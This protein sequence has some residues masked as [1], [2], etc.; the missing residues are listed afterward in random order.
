MRDRVL[1]SHE[2]VVGVLGEFGVVAPEESVA[3]GSGLSLTRGSA[4]CRSS[5][6]EFAR[7][8]VV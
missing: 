3:G 2:G 6:E 1:D 7:A 4:C 8:T 5:T